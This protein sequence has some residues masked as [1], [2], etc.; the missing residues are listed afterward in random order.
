MQENDAEYK[1]SPRYMPRRNSV[2]RIYFGR[3]VALISVLCFAVCG[4]MLI[5][6]RKNGVRSVMKINSEKYFF[7]SVAST[8]FVADASEKA[9]ALKNSGGAGYILNDGN[10]L[11]MA[12]VY[13]NEGDA[14]TVAKRLS[15]AGMP[16][17]VYEF[18]TPELKVE[19]TD[20]KSRNAKVSELFSY[21]KTLVGEL[22]TLSR[23]IDAS[24]ISEPLAL[25]TVEKLRKK[26][27]NKAD[28]I[29]DSDGEYTNALKLMYSRFDN[30][31]VNALGYGG[32]GGVRSAVKE[33]AC[34]I[35][36][37]NVLCSRNIFA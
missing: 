20:D 32:N 8:E 35:A 21:P 6:A 30:A 36:A 31:F 33:L 4:A 7:V 13:S 24:E 15:D 25:L 14:A 3:V 2:R 26:M 1:K 10:F 19:Y 22:E 34:A 12:A 23:S 16:A 9:L 29:G 5:L 11:V 37:E 18:F 28:G 17:L 27:Q